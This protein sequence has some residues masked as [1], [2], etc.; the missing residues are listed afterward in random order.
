MEI[1]KKFTTGSS[2]FDNPEKETLFGEQVDVNR[3]VPGIPT[4]ED[5][6]NL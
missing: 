2:K 6:R 3:Y 5:Y 1:N 4:A